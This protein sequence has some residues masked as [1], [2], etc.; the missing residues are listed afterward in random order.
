MA[1]LKPCPFCG[2]MAMEVEK[3]SRLTSSFH[4]EISATIQC[5]YCGAN[6]KKMWYEKK[7]LNSNEQFLNNV[8]VYDLWNRRD[9]NG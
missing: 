9:D 8:T 1:E 3:S 6:I 7:N 4:T 5:V 2:G